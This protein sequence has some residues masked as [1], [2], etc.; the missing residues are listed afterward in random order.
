VTDWKTLKQVARDLVVSEAT[1][2]REIKAER[3]KAT[4]IGDQYRIRQCW[5]ED[6]VACRSNVGSSGDAG[7]GVAHAWTLAEAR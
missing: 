4:R 7:D 3:L 2:R 5:V 6:Y 1:I